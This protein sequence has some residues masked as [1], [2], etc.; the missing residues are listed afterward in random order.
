MPPADDR[1]R[2][3]SCGPCAGPCAGPSL[4]VPELL[5]LKPDAPAQSLSQGGQWQ[6]EA[7]IKG[8]VGHGSE[9]YCM[10]LKTHS[11][12]EQKARSLP[13]HLSPQLHSLPI[14]DAPP[15]CGTLDEPSPTSRGLSKCRRHAVAPPG[16][17]TFSGSGEVCSRMKLP[18]RYHTEQF[19]GPKTPLCSL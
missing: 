11:K 5:N 6:P 2:P 18:L 17:C 3:G 13:A 16:C 8:E 14:T 15:Q 9:H 19:R 7:L 4:A 10:F 1:P 12:A